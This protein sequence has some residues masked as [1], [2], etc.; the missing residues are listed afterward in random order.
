LFS[1][2]KPTTEYEDTW[3]QQPLP[4]EFQVHVQARNPASGQLEL[5]Q[6]TGAVTSCVRG[7]EA[8]HLDWKVMIAAFKE[9]REA[10]ALSNV[11]VWMGVG[12][13]VGVF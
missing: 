4:E 1:C 3:L 7:Q 5:V 9:L 10:V 12:V 11:S 8:R 2:G 13:G 6:E